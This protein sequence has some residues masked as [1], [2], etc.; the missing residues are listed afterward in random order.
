MKC[1]EKG[2]FFLLWAFSKERRAAFF[3]R[4]VLNSSMLLGISQKIS[5]L[6]L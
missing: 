2:C 5:E 1:Q 6:N 3:W 4:S